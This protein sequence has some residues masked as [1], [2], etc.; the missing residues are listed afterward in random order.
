M[1]KV[2]FHW[3]YEIKLEMYYHQPVDVFI[4]SYDRGKKE[5]IRIIVIKEP[6]DLKM[7]R[8]VNKY[9]RCYDHVLTYNDDILRGNP[10]ARLFIGSNTWINSYKFPEKKFSVSTVVGGKT[11]HILRGYAFRR[12]LWRDRDKI[13][14]P[15]EFYLS[16]S[17][18]MNTNYEDQLVLGNLKDPLFN[19]Q[20][21]IV[22]ENK[23]IKNMFTEK[24]IDCFQTKTVPIYYGATN[25]ADFFNPDGILQ[26]N[27][28][29]HA[30]NIC[31]N[32][33]PETYEKMLPAIE[34]NYQRSFK[35]ANF[36]EQLKKAIE[37]IWN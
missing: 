34:D 32:L 21:H 23:S 5:S 8:Y 14:I 35:W 11:S 18:R 19:S 33:T 10:K 31:N 30:I 7:V 2:R 13:I 37:E 22:I 12:Q 4:D 25:I 15:K 9:F 20:F 36:D 16:G 26:F 27:N 3:N 1:Y 24:L 28:I 17:F 29:D 6:Y